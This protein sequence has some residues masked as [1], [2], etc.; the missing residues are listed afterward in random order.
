MSVHCPYHTD[1]SLVTVLPKSR[2][3]SAGGLLS[4]KLLHRI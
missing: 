1:V 4:I 2:G 3:T